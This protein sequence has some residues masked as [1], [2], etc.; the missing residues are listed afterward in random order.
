MTRLRKLDVSFTKTQ[1]GLN[2][3]VGFT[4]LVHLNAE[5]TELGYGESFPSLVQ[6]FPS[7]TVRS[8]STLSLRRTPCVCVS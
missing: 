5:G 6:N 8:F 4:Q 7:L 1:K 3:L 2:R